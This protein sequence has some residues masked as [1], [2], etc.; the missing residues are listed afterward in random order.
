MADLRSTGMTV[1]RRGMHG[2]TVPTGTP[3][4]EAAALL[5]AGRAV[6]IDYS[7]CLSGE[8]ASGG[9]GRRAAPIRAAG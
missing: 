4:A 2:F 7:R 8:A 3:I 6:G 1:A 9:T 5:D